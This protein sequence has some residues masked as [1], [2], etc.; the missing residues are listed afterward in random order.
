MPERRDALVG[1]VLDDRYRI[2]RRVARGGMSTV[3][4]GTDLNLRRQVA[5]KVL[6]PHLADSTQ[7]VE[8]FEAEAIAAARL[9]DPN[10]VNVY[11]QGVDG[12]EAYLVMEYV[13]GVTLRDVIKTQ[14]AMTPRVA[15]EV[16]DAV[17]AGLAAA[18]AANMVHRDIKPENVLISADGRIKLA[19]F[20]LSR[21]ASEHTAT[22]GLV[23]TVAYVSPEL[24]TGRGADERTD[25]YACGILLYE[26]LT[27][28]QPYTGETTWDVAMRHVNE[29][30]PA[31]S[32]VVPE[33]S[34][35]FDH[36]VAWATEHQPDDRPPHAGDFLKELRRIEDHLSADELD[37]GDEPVTLHELV[38]ATQNLL[39]RTQPADD[40]P[41]AAEDAAAASAG[42]QDAEPESEAASDD[43]D[44]DAATTFVPM[45][46]DDG[47]SVFSPPPPDSDTSL[48]PEGGIP[49]HELRL[50][51]DTQSQDIAPPADSGPA[52]DAGHTAAPSQHSGG[53]APASD[54]VAGPRTGRAARKPS[55]SVSKPG[56]KRK[57][58]FIALIV[59]IVTLL[60]GT[61]AWWFGAGPGAEIVV[62]EL[63][64]QT[65]SSAISQLEEAGTHASTS[66][67]Y[68]TTVE[69]GKVISSDPKAG[70]TVRRYQGVNLVI[71]RGPR[72]ISVP[73]LNGLDRDAAETQLK[74]SKLKLGDVSE[75]HDEA[76]AGLVIEQSEQIGAQI[77]EGSAVDV[78]LS[79]GPAPVEVPQVRGRSVSDAKD[80]LKAAGFTVVEGEPEFSDTYREG[81]VIRS[82]PEGG[83]EVKRGSEIEIIVSKG[84]DVVEVPNVKFKSRD[85]ATR[86]L[87]EAGFKV[88][89]EEGS[90]GTVIDSVVKQDPGAGQMAKRG[91]TITIGV[92]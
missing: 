89:V 64:N 92:V 17:L 56:T 57:A 61:G 15:L 7:A 31:P 40:E 20:G 60:G 85:E 80:L 12:S 45:A 65:E 1:E 43:I 71:S 44:N 37:L 74:N 16:M 81:N 53:A 23:G 59:F 32:D 67:D 9:T 35:D 24:V 11:D 51:A 69:K 88:A 25:I 48:V 82:S 90:F 42:A 50:P 3:Y 41:S 28:H 29:T 72:M 4:L 27:G 78:V 46:R 47:T 6:R 76:K 73:N 38:V 54:A 70:D 55:E 18:H 36:L 84:P 68:S 63:K 21:A 10:V 86:I 14:G 33:L 30:V 87:E 75:R 58:W 2:E 49:Q 52:Y 91:S 19:D 34:E 62:P 22:G 26:L 13:P 5:L 77:I 8:R 83:E 39:A 66:E 79:S